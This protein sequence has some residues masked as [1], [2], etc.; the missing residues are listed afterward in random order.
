MSKITT[1]K[2]R[3]RFELYLNEQDA[4][5]FKRVKKKLNGK[6]SE[7]IKKVIRKAGQEL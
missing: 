3:N 1:P 6:M 5:I 7:L 4:K 2:K